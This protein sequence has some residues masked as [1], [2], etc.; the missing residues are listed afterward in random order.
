MTIELTLNGKPTAIEL[1][2]MTR[3]I[4]ALRGPLGLTGTKEGCGEGEC[5]SCT[6]LLDGEPVNACLVVI[7]QCRDR[8]ITTVE[9][10]GDAQHLSPLQRSL[11]E[12]GGTQCGFC[13]PGVLLAAEALLASN[14]SPSAMEVR[15]A[16][17]GNLCRCTGYERIV[18]GVLAAAELRRT[19]KPAPEVMP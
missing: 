10:L 13:T 18:Q 17:A 16:L 2:P 15:T 5:G 12:H 8:Q 9:G 7:G 3:L 4:D 11:N 6:I 1:P 14:P 19:P